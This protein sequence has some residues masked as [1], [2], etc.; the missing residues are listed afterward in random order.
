[1]TDKSPELKVATL[2]NI[3]TQVYYDCFD[4][5]QCSLRN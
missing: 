3:L 1:M 5:I 2:Y 4:E